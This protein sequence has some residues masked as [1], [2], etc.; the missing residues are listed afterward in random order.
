MG[1]LHRRGLAK[2]SVARAVSALRSFY[3]FLSVQHG[4]EENPAASVRM[5]KLERRLPAVLDRAQV[6]MMFEFGETLAQKG[7]FT[8]AACHDNLLENKRI[9]VGKILGQVVE[10][11]A[12]KTGGVRLNS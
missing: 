9:V 1:E 10:Q 6:D 12:D 5:P 8:D 3:R 4:V 7:G 2:R 11:E